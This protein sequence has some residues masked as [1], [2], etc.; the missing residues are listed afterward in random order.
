MGGGFRV[1]ELN[2]ANCTRRS[3]V[4][5]FSFKGEI[6]RR[7]ALL[8]TYGLVLAVFI[9]AGKRMLW[10]SDLK[11][12]E[13]VEW[14]D[15]RKRDV[16]VFKMSFPFGVC[17]TRGT[18]GSLPLPRTPL[19]TLVRSLNFLGPFLNNESLNESSIFGVIK[20]AWKLLEFRSS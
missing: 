14:Q 2:I 16:E 4:R 9:L 10:R 20:T 12:L 5:F 19:L 8:F 1:I 7:D 18:F 13:D 6:R 3:W 15:G 17:W 11:D